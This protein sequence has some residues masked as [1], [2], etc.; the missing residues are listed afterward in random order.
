MSSA[1]I[2][3]STLENELVQ[4]TQWI[5]TKRAVIEKMVG[6]MG[7]LAQQYVE[8]LQG[9]TAD[10]IS[11]ITAIAPKISKG[12]NYHGLPYVVLDYPRCFDKENIFAVRTLFWWGNFFSLTLHLKGTYKKSCEENIAAYY[13]LLKKEGFYI[14]VA[15]DE[16][17]FRFT[18]ENYQPVS[19]MKP[20][21]FEKII[22]SKNFIK[23][24]IKIPVLQWEEAG[25]LLFTN[26][27]QYCW[28]TALSS[29]NDEKDLSPDSPITG[30]GL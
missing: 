27:K 29:P 9:L 22:A 7:A 24:A 28:L 2:Q 26:F 16:W 21:A 18:E 20:E 10:E 30:S 3:L 19:S 6:W 8:Y 5:L 14:C 25:D 11:I 17:D 4:N 13:P 23:L 15:A 1:K 12:E